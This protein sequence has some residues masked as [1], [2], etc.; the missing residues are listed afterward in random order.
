MSRNEKTPPANEGRLNKATGNRD[1]TGTTRVIHRW[2]FAEILAELLAVFTGAPVTL[3]LP[4]FPQKLDW[5]PLAVLPR[6]TLATLGLNVVVIGA[7]DAHETAD[8]DV[9]TV[10]DLVFTAYLG[11]EI[12]PRW[13]TDYLGDP[14]DGDG[15]NGG[16]GLPPAPEPNG[17]TAPSSDPVAEGYAGRG[18]LDVFPLPAGQKSPPPVGLTG[19]AGVWTDEQ[20][21]G[22]TFAPGCNYGLRAPAG[23]IAIDVDDYA[24]GSTIK[25]GATTLA[26]LEAKLG[27]LP[28][29]WRTSARGAAN[30][31]GQRWFR[32]PALNHYESSAG[33]DVEVIHRHHRYAVLPPSNHPEG[34]RY[35][36]ISPDGQV[37][38]A[39]PLVGRLPELPAAWVDYLTA[40]RPPVPGST[41]EGRQRATR[42]LSD[43]HR[44]HR[45]G[46]A[47][48][49]APNGKTR[50]FMSYIPQKFDR[51]TSRY[52]SMVGLFWE[53]ARR[54]AETDS[55][56]PEVQTHEGIWDA[57]EEI[58]AEYRRRV[59]DDRSPG[60]VEGEIHRAMVGAF[61]K[62][63]GA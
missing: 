40:S 6:A 24:K 44:D 35:E 33:R 60:A 39:V 50:A 23:V 27:A 4:T 58:S 11:H 51:G 2:N 7:A 28:P 13:V 15:G 56:A 63:R 43:M 16:G 12:R 3:A 55:A 29:T 49:G 14:P 36:W 32:V 31:S 30:P 34:G 61:A 46:D 54:D 1:E 19:G 38:G 18:W 8:P 5:S 17:P 20:R 57:L 47:T 10:E 41:P 53:A 37:L 62:V 9:S 21:A 22:L 25:S 26:E 45:D 48:R 52:D 59:G 42:R